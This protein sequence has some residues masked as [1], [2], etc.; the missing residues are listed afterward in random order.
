[1]CSKFKLKK[2]LKTHGVWAAKWKYTLKGKKYS[3]YGYRINSR[4]EEKNKQFFNL[5]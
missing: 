2:Q 1:M 3:K 5:Q 4:K